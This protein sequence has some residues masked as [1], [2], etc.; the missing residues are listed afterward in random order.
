MATL[1]LFFRFGYS[2]E[3]FFFILL[4]LSSPV[5]S[6][7][8]KKDVVQHSC[9]QTFC[10]KRRYKI[11]SLS[12]FPLW[13]HYSAFEISSLPAGHQWQEKKTEES[14]WKQKKRVLVSSMPPPFFFFF[15]NSKC[16]KSC[17]TFLYKVTGRL[18]L[19]WKVFYTKSQKSVLSRKKK[20][21]I[22]LKA[23]YEGK[24]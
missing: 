8:R 13:S 21:T 4:E 16:F 24:R 11:V 2:W 15:E 18:Q 23:Y 22:R 10:K 14:S 3:A 6:Y 5:C 1:Q 9:K 7:F 12:V 17:K 20:T 19:F